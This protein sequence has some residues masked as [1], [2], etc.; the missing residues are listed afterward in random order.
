MAIRHIVISELIENAQGEAYEE[1]AVD[2]I[3]QYIK[4]VTIMQLE[5]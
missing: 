1:A 2:L 4:D 5:I 3:R